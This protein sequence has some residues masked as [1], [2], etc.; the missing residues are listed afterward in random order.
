M[1]RPGWRFS[2]F[3]FRSLQRHLR[4]G[5]YVA[6][7][8]LLSWLLMQFV[9]ECGH[10]LGAWLTGRTVLQV[11][12]HPLQISETMVDPKPSPLAVIWSGPLFGSIVPVLLWQIV[13]WA[14]VGG[15]AE[16]RFFAGFCLIANGAYIGCGVFDPVGDAFDLVQQ[17]TP[18]WL[19]GLFGLIAI[20]P[21]I[22]LWDG[23]GAKLGIGEQ[24][25]PVSGRRIRRVL[26]ATLVVVIVELAW[27]TWQ[28]AVSISV[29]LPSTGSTAC[30]V[31][32]VDRMNIRRPVRND[33]RRGAQDLFDQQG[34]HQ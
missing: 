7:L 34:F 30:E 1:T 18:R 19:L 3:R 32:F 28:P 6:A 15:E 4:A 21:G 22:W 2:G 25:A 9:H 31:S 27:S 16:C 10:V 23:T 24:A 13:R 8:G 5:F 33:I 17:G 12:L 26:I 14:R 11:V 29:R 20:P